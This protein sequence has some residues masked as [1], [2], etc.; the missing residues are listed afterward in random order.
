MTTNPLRIDR[1]KRAAHSTAW[2]DDGDEDDDSPK[3]LRLYNKTRPKKKGDPEAGIHPIE[4]VQ[5]DGSIKSPTDEARKAT[6]REGSGDF[7]HPSH[8]PT[9]PGP[10]GKWSNSPKGTAGDEINN[11]DVNP[12]SSSTENSTEKEKETEAAETP[13][14]ENGLRRRKRDKVMPWRKDGR[15]D[16]AEKRAEKKKTQPSTAHLTVVQ[17]IKNVFLSWINLALVFVP[18]GIAM[19]SSIDYHPQTYMAYILTLN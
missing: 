11:V 16:R 1:L 2:Y 12:G 8:A 6:F 13:A 7:E 3:I 9:F 18:V 19:G 15:E 17:Q 5:T 4:H 10:N 14:D